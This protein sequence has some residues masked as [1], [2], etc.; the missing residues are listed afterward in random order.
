MP[1]TRRAWWVLVATV[2][3]VALTARLGFW[4]LDRAAQKVAL[5]QAREQRG[6]LPPLTASDLPQA[7]AAS[8]D[9]EPLWHRQVTL[10]GRWVPGETVYLDNRPMGGRTGFFVVTPLLLGDGR[11][12]LVQRGWLPRHAVERTRIAPYRSSA[13]VIAVQG[14]LAPTPSRLYELGEAASGVIRQNLAIADRARETGRALLPLVVVQDGTP[15]DADDGLARQWPQPASDVHKHYGYAFQWFGL[16]GL[17]LALYVWFQLI[18]P[19]RRAAPV[20]PR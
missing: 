8:A 7:A 14:R 12:L 17:A 6:S 10:Q 16:C 15:A 13:D 3:T 11:A 18:R 9:A 1:V 4:Q 20:G 2:L 5:Q 19:Q